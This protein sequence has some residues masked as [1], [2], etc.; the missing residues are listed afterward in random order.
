MTDL[1]TKFSQALQIAWDTIQ[2]TVP[3]LDVHRPEIGQ[4]DLTY[5][6][7]SDHSWVD[8]FWS[9]QL[10][11]AY[12]VTRESFFLDAARQQRSYFLARLDR[13]ET[14]DHD[15]GFLY[16][17]SL[18]V[19]YKLIGDAQ[20]RQGALRAAD[21]LAKRYN[22]KGRFIRAWNEWPGKADNRGR[23]IVDCME[24]LALLYWAWAQTGKFD[25]ADVANAHAHTTLRY[26]VRED[27]STNHTYCFDPDTGEPLRAET[28][29]GF[30]D[31]SCW[32]RGQAWAIHGFSVAHSYTGDRAYLKTAVKLADYA[33]A[34]LPPDFVPYWDYLLPED[35]PHYRDSSA[36]A[37]TAA[38]LLL[39]SDRVG[40]AA[41]TAHY[42]D[43]AHNILTSLIDHYTTAGYPQAEGLLL[44]GSANVPS[45]SFNTML[46]YGD[47]FYIEA[48]LRALGRKE[49]AW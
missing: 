47:Y 25:Y 31:D 26:L 40:N 2:R 3:K 5:A 36:A 15:L 48:L 43:T 23:I 34:H 9:G 21:A 42:R 45:G 41:Q 17:H 28:H 19:E 18:V 29:Q 11:L 12:A 33:I 20:A 14:H 1:Q 24:N 46:P 44:E 13:P 32:S 38:G 27:G 7:S 37:I 16:T 39:L 22:G 30:A 8:G 10:W 6:R 49:F 4:A 35:A